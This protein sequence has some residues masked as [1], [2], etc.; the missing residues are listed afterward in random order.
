LGIEAHRGDLTD[1][2]SLVAGAKACDGVIHTAFINDF[3]KFAANA[4]Y[5]RLA[6]E[7][8]GAVLGAGQPFVVTSGTAATALLDPGHLG[9]EDDA[10]PS[11]LP[12]IAS[13]E[14]ALAM[15]SRGVRASV[16]RLSPSVHGEGD[17]GF[18]PAIIDIAREKGVSAYVGDGANRWPGVHRLDA[19]NLYRL[20]LEKGSGGV[21]YHG[22]ADSGVPFREIAE[23]I[24]RRLGLPV[25]SKAPD[26]AADHFGFLGMFVGLD[27]PA[28]S[29]KTQAA[30]GWRPTR[31]GLLADI[32]Q[33]YYF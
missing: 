18:V 29:A 1:T 8:M 27:C 23:I 11:G 13:E 5:D 4:E 3:S 16:I 2:D 24:G 14:L 32:D 33:P 30:L 7:A 6:I 20:A 12:R 25:V 21:R 26:E 22:V 19:A 31:T 15:A 10:P 9:T 17:H 28:S